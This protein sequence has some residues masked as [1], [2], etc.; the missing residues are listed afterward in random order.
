M[1]VSAILAPIGPEMALKMSRGLSARQC[2]I[3]GL[4]A[5]VSRMQHGELKAWPVAP[6]DEWRIGWPTISWSYD[7]ALMQVNTSLIAHVLHGV[8]LHKPE[9]RRGVGQHAMRMG[10][11]QSTR[12]AQSIAARALASLRTRQLL[13]L[14]QYSAP[15]RGPRDDHR[16][17][18]EGYA[19]TPDALPVARAHEMDVPDLRLR[20][21]VLTTYAWPRED[22]PYSLDWCDVPERLEPPV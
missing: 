22:G 20:W 4:A 3:L 10:T 8:V 1:R 13:A 12:T 15:L 18:D 5:A 2:R 19:L 6:K 16:R 21:T 7:D 11:E 14:R 17:F 9:I